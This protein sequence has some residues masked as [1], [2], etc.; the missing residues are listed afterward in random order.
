MLL[1]ATMTSGPDQERTGVG[2]RGPDSWWEHVT[3]TSSVEASPQL[4]TELRE[5]VTPAVVAATLVARPRSR[6]GVAPPR[7]VAPED[8]L[9]EPSTNLASLVD[10]IEDAVRRGKTP[11]KAVIDLSAW[12]QPREALD[13]ALE[14]FRRRAESI[15]HFKIPSGF[16]NLDNGEWYLGPRSSDL[17]WPAM[18]D[19]LSGRL[20]EV[21]REV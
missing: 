16:F 6:F 4:A 10:A 5:Q 20:G 19:S 21:P 3:T 11:E 15:R 1:I 13:Q 7:S 14:S 12:V 8:D 9:M 17:L 18:R 2:S